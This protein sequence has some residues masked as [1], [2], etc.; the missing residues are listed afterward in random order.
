MAQC[1]GAAITDV[2]GLHVIMILQRQAA[3][4]VI[5]MAVAAVGNAT[6]Q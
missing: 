2:E 3:A 1:A 4:E 5:L 6:D